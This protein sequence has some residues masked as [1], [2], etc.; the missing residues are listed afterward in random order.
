MGDTMLTRD[1]V[2][3]A[4][5]AFTGLGARHFS[6]GEILDHITRLGFEIVQE[7]RICSA[8]VYVDDDTRV[9]FYNHLAAPVMQQLALGHELAHIV[10]KHHLR[11]PQNHNDTKIQETEA[12]NIAWTLAVPRSVYYLDRKNGTSLH[13]PLAYKTFLGIGATHDDAEKAA[14]EAQ[15]AAESE[16]EQLA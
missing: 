6:P 3:K 2:L 1:H 10:L 7:P 11:P 8:Y 9:V 4:K 13:K 12:T 16:Y 14:T 15:A 5:A